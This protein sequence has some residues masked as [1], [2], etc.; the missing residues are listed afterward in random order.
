ML[1]NPQA[2]SQ[3]YAMEAKSNASGWEHSR[4]LLASMCPKYLGR[5]F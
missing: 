3:T 5:G 2:F 4:A 1:Y